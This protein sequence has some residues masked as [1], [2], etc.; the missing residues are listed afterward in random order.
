MNLIERINNLRAA[1]FLNSISYEN[2]KE[3]CIIDAEINRKKAPKKKDIDAWYNKHKHFCRTIIKTKGVTTRIYSYS[4]T[5]PAGLGGRLFSGGSLQGISA[6]YRGLL[7]RGIATDIDMANAHPVIL[8]WIC[9]I[10]DIPCPNLEYYINN[11]ADILACFPDRAKGKRAFLIATNTD[12]M[13]ATALDPEIL[14][15]YNKEM[16]RIQKKIVKLTEYKDIFDTIPEYKTSRN[17]NGSAINRILCFYENQILQHAVHVINGSGL[18]IAILMFDGL[19]VYGDHYENTALLEAIRARVE[20]QMPGLNMM[21][22]YKPHDTS[23]TIP[24]DFDE[25]DYLTT[26]SYST[27]KTNFEINIAK[28]IE[29]SVFI[30]ETPDEVILLTENK[31]TVSYKH[32]KAEDRKRPFIMDWIIDPT[33]RVYEKMGM[34]PDAA[35]CPRDVYN[36]WRPFAIDQ[37][38]GEY[39][40]RP[41]GEQMIID[42]IRVLCNYQEEVVN[43]VLLWM[44][45]MLQFPENKSI[46]VTFISQQGSGKGTFMK[47]MAQLL[48]GKRVFETANPSRD[49]W[50]D[51]NGHMTTSFLVNLNELSRK[52]TIDSEGK[53][54]ALV[55]DPTVTINF[56]GINQYQIPSF[57]RFLITTNNEQPVKTSDDD[58]RN[59]IIRCSDDKRGDTDYFKKLNEYLDDDDVIRTIGATLKT[60]IVAEKFNQ[61]PIPRTKY[62]DDLKEASAPTHEVWFRGFVAVHSNDKVVYMYPNEFWGDYKSWCEQNGFSIDGMNSIKLGVRINNL[63]KPEERDQFIETAQNGKRRKTFH[64]PALLTH[65]DIV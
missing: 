42:H 4:Q 26:N 24:D 17:Y 1:H 57:H 14:Q 40:P 47:L 62:Q 23:I 44:A 59:L 3:T 7:M 25:N 45:H 27:L 21:W 41:D 31:L 5:T 46:V 8:R 29:S 50:G 15:E 6:I 61:Y 10:H 35:K 58:R 54:K 36:L 28:I 65:F 11:R 53:I 49:V 34:F 32:L 63:F 39:T 22:A 2:F 52:D 48:G 30:K 43:Y 33:M 16:M 37:F 60:M 51:F 64:I 55:T 12:K 13:V 56:K 9:H 19:M 38:E 20:E 18:E